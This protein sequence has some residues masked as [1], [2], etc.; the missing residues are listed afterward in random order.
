MIG[1]SIAA[2]VVTC[3]LLFNTICTHAL[4]LTTK[5]LDN[6]KTATRSWKTLCGTVLPLA[7]FTA[8]SLALG[9]VAYIQLNVAAIHV[10]KALTPVLVCI[11]LFIAGLADITW[12]KCMDIIV[13]SGGIVL[14][15]AGWGQPALAGVA[16]QVAST[17]TDAVR[18]VIAQRALVS[19]KLGMEPLVLMYHLAPLA[20]IV[21]MV[22]TFATATPTPDEIC[23]NWHFLLVNSLLCFSLD[24]AGFSVVSYWFSH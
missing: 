3:H 11:L 7:V 14:A 17:S 21:S 5:L 2:F 8:S 24:I 12:V 4:A 18:L 19:P 20:C 23:G 6:H 22:P 10:L 13:I 9:N 1:T 15:S 16:M